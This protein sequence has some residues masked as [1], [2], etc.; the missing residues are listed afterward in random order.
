MNVVLQRNVRRRNVNLRNKKPDPD[1]TVVAA[2]VA[3]A[4]VM[5]IWTGRTVN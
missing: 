4:C 1:T 5:D 2:A 3:V